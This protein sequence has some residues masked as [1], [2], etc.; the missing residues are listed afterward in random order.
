MNS[1][2]TNEYT[3]VH[4]LFNNNNTVCIMLTV[5]YLYDIADNK[6]NYSQLK[7]GFNII[8]LYN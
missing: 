4:C 7:D 8:L 3:T 6:L 5:V 2:E 1:A